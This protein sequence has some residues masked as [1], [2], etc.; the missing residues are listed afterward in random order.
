VFYLRELAAWSSASQISLRTVAGSGSPILLR[1]AQLRGA[2]K[3]TGLCVNAR[4]SYD[5]IWC[6]SAMFCTGAECRFSFLVWIEALLI[7]P[8]LL[9]ACSRAPTPARV[10]APFIA[11]PPALVSWTVAESATE[12][13]RVLAA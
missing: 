2:Q 11:R 1:A 4:C 9:A 5:K 8:W 6:L 13:G 10:P 7:V 12:D 3:Q